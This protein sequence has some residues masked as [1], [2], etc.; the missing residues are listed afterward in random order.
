MSSCTWAW[1]GTIQSDTTI[2]TT[3][4]SSVTQSHRA[5]IDTDLI[6]QARR[7]ES[8]TPDDTKIFGATGTEL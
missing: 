7:D 2:Q 4:S 8:E 1:Y 6:W 3:S 5:E